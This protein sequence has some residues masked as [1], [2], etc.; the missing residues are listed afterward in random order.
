[1]KIVYLIH[2]LHNPGGM[3]R[4]VSVKASWLAEHGCD[5]RILTASLRSRK[6]FFPLSDKVSVMDLGTGDSFGPALRRYGKALERALEDI[7][8]DICISSGGNEIYALAESRCSCAKIAEYHFS[9]DK[10]HLKY[11]FPFFGR[12]VAN[13]RLARLT[14]A[15]AKM[16]RFVVLTK[17]DRRD[18]ERKL[19]NVEQIYNPLTINVKELS[20]LENERFVAVGRLSAEK[21]WPA[22]IEIWAKVLVRHPEWKLDIYGDGKLRDSLQKRI[23]AM[24][25]RGK[26]TLCGA[27]PDIAA[28]MAQASGLLLTSEREGFGLVLIEAAACAL[29]LVSSACP[30]GPLELIEDGVSGFLLPCGDTDAFVEAVCRLIEDRELRLRMGRNALE[31]SRKFSLDNVMGRWLELFRSLPD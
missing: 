1:M 19:S 10:F 6:P 18:W 24:G 4:V 7:C 12:I 27:D 17:A 29:P 5:V 25:L 11:A 31:M 28:R 9:R 15:A 20:K 22:M 3:E 30:V 13:W 2:S 16:D 21:N 14:A 26:V 8:P 23:D